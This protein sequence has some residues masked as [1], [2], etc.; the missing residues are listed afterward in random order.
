MEKKS[1][2][3]GKENKMM[4]GAGC[5]GRGRPMKSTTS[6]SVTK[7]GGSKGRAGSKARGSTSKGSK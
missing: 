1:K 5:G 2:G 4:S 3:M 6:R 7:A